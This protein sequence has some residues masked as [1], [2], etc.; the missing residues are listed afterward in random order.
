MSRGNWGKKVSEND[1]K[2]EGG[3]TYYGAAPLVDDRESIL[4]DLPCQE[5]GMCISHGEV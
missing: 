5:L 3:F 4:M 2:K 1:K